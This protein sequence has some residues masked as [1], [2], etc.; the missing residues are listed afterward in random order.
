M[1]ALSGR[2]SGVAAPN[3]RHGYEKKLLREIGKMNGGTAGHITNNVQITS[4]RPVNDA[5]E[6]LMQMA[7]LRNL[8]RR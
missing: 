7:R 5:S 1:S 8:R 6:M 4:D 3:Q 2:S